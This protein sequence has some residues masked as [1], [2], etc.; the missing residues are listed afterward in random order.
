MDSK[1]MGK[2]LII[3]AVIITFI[4]SSEANAIVSIITPDSSEVIRFFVIS[5]E[6]TSMDV[7]AVKS[8]V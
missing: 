1:L 6:I 5:G 4:S 3:I 7:N 2:Y 8:I